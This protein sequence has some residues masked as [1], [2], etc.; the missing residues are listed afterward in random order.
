MPYVNTFLGLLESNTDSQYDDPL[1]K[2]KYL[3]NYRIK[4]T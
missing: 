1:V 4:V 2:V 3:E